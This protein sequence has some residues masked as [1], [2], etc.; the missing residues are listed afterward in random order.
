MVPNH[1]PVDECG[2]QQMIQPKIDEA[3]ARFDLN[4][5]IFGDILTSRFLSREKSINRSRQETATK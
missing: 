1:Q 5:A 3:F 2:I 4:Q